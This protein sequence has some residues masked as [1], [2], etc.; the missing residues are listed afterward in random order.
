MLILKQELIYQLTTKGP[1][2]TT[3]GSSMGERQYWEMSEGI[4]TGEKI[5]TRIV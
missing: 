1:L 5:R 4:L 2:P 3:S